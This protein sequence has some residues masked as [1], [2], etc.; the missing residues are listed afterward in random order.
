MTYDGLGYV[1]RLNLTIRPW[2]LGLQNLFWGRFVSEEHSVVWIEWQGDYAL[3]VLILNGK[4]ISN[5]RISEN[6]VKCD[7]FELTLE[8]H[9]TIR[10][11]SLGETFV[12][13]IPAALKI[14]PIDFLGGSEEK[15]LSRGQ[16]NFV[17]GS[18]ST[19][20]VIHERVSWRKNQT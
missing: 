1:E 17:D 14:A 11:G 16:L 12:S 19:G 2:Q 3:T 8:R 15:F 13:K 18:Q 6:G 20:W 7:D 9:A 5:S 4:K 10:K